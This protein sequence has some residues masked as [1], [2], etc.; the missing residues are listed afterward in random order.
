VQ[1][2]PALFDAIAS[3]ELHLTAVLLLGS[4]LTPENL[5]DVLARAKHRTKRE[6]AQLV[7]QLDPLP[8]VPA[9]IEPLGPVPAHGLVS[10]RKPSWG[11]MM[12]ALNPV[13]NLNPGER[14]RDWMAETLTAVASGEP[15]GESSTTFEPAPARSESNSIP[16]QSE[17]AQAATPPA[18]WPALAGGTSPQRYSVQF[19][20]T[21]EYIDLVERAKALL[22]SS[23]EGASLAEVHLRALRELVASLEKR[24]YGA[25]GQT[26]KPSKRGSRVPSSASDSSS[27]SDASTTP[28]SNA[29]TGD[30]PLAT[31]EPV[32]AHGRSR[33]A[34]KAPRQRGRYVP[35]NIRREVFDRDAARCTFVDASGQRCRE[36]HA[37]ELHHLLPFARNGEHRTSNLTLRCRAHN[38]LAAEADFGREHI[39]QQRHSARHDS[40]SRARATASTP[41]PPHR[42]S[43]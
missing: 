6:V 4:H 26:R 11:A 38:A 32:E 33:G 25:P 43:G 42:S 39:E 7:R 34:T 12:R 2:F 3:G 5:A 17:S 8:D 31:D 10:L 16:T 9:R 21:S 30:A 18:A 28:I 29:D 36:S 22:S 41:E 40:F 37:L 20:A 19:T 1:R 23:H 35:A 27:K 24:K 14:P 13:R 15:N